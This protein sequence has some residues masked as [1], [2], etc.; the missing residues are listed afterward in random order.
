MTA[1][2]AP[3]RGG[4]TALLQPTL[5]LTA[6]ILI[7]VA[8][9]CPNPFTSS[10]VSIL[11]IYPY[12]ASLVT[13][14]TASAAAATTFTPTASV[15]TTTSNSSASPTTTSSASATS[16]TVSSSSSNISFPSVTST[17]SSSSTTTSDTSSTPTTNS[18]AGQRRTVSIAAAAFPTL[19]LNEKSPDLVTGGNASAANST[20]DL[21]PSQLSLLEVKYGPLGGCFTDLSGRR[22]CSPA[23]LA[24]D[25]EDFE[26]DLQG[27]NTGLIVTGLPSRLRVTPI[28]LLIVL[29]G[30]GL[31]LATS[32]PMA[33]TRFGPTAP[34]FARHLSPDSPVQRYLMRM[35]VLLLYS[36]LALALLLLGSGISL[37]MV[38]GTAVTAF[39]AA[40]STR[41]LAASMTLVDSDTISL[42]AG[43]G[44]AFGLIWATVALLLIEAFLERR[45]ARREDA[46]AQAR[47]DIEGQYGREVFEMLE[48]QKGAR[49]LM[50]QP[51]APRE[52]VYVQAPAPTAPVLSRAPSTR[53]V[54]IHQSPQQPS[55][56]YAQ[57][58]RQQSYTST[59]GFYYHTPDQKPR[60][61]QAPPSASPFA[62]PT[63]V[64]ASDIKSRPY[65]PEEDR[66]I[67]T[68]PSLECMAHRVPVPAEN[69]PRSTSPA[70]SYWTAGP[71]AERARAKQAPPKLSFDR[72]RYSEEQQARDA[73]E[74][75]RYVTAGRMATALE[76]QASNASQMTRNQIERCSSPDIDERQQRA[77]TKGTVGLGKLRYR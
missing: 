50:T 39:N 63:W 14:T 16:S 35:S 72:I 21:Q 67:H 31:L 57:P 65:H 70:P 40:N 58:E 64:E 27:L 18:T 8:F 46:I 73:A 22:F 20:A 76:R 15:P 24:S 41:R 26:Q 19:F 29:V 37:R 30:T 69:T 60:E 53:T 10:G 3:S 61:W 48:G 11:T 9:L 6:L 62:G 33:L 49:P 28:L 13:S 51:T 25:F 2:A 7:F 43:I 17:P 4:L 77:G 5:Q 23:S 42:M 75:T 54:F 44:N 38:A 68:Q 36:R 1:V 55:V 32:M 34:A 52:V 66:Y 47:K 56:S 12:D 45:R 74:A 71:V 59:D